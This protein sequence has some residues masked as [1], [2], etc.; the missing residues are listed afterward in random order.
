MNKKLILVVI[1][2]VILTVALCSCN[3]FD[4]SPKEGIEYSGNFKI[5][6]ERTTGN[7]VTIEFYD[8]DTKV[9]YLFVKMAQGAGLTM[10]VNADGTPKLYEEEN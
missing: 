5:I 1:L 4:R 8:V 10:L 2:V 9:M 6:S 3:Y 7:C